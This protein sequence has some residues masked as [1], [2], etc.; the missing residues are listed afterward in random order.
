M[1][2][3]MGGS[4][5][6]RASSQ[7]YRSR[8]GWGAFASACDAVVR[9]WLVLT[10]WLGLH[11]AARLHRLARI[12]HP[13]RFVRA[14]I[15]P[16]GRRIALAIAFLPRRRRAEAAIAF[17]SCKAV[18]AFDGADGVTA[19]VAY[20][21]GE[22]SGVPRRVAAGTGHRAHQLDALLAARLPLLRAALKRLP[23]DAGRRCCVIIEQ[24]GEG[25]LRARADRR[26]G[27]DHVY[28]EAVVCAAR[29]V[30]PTVR[31]PDFACRAAGRALQ[32]ASAIADASSGDAREM[33]LYQALRELPT[34]PRLLQWLPASVE[35]GS[36]AA[37][38]LLAVSTYR[39]YLQQ[40]AAPVPRRLRHPL[41]AAL[42]A[43]CSR[44]AYLATVDSIEDSFREALAVLATRLDGPATVRPAHLDPAPPSS[45]DRSAPGG[46][47]PVG[48]LAEGVPA[49]VLAERSGPGSAAQPGA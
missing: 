8:F 44:R 42:A 6:R 32:L 10:A 29:L 4:V 37:A 36:R 24:V 18:F 41:G 5:R 3:G 19:A 48:E 40:I 43:A 17:L 46:G 30:A 1:Q 20:L 9:A 12:R 22:S 49:T 26:C 33:L 38:T 23:G 35:G 13:L 7:A 31:P 39:F 11:R 27:V 45:D 14:A 15:V 25:L 47:A 16:A 21:T 2:R 34:V 28:G